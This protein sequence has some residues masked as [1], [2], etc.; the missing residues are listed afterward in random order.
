MANAVNILISK[1]K[2]DRQMVDLSS[3]NITRSE[4]EGSTR[5]EA[6]YVTLGTNLGTVS[7]V[8]KGTVHR[9]IDTILR[10]EVQIENT[11]VGKADTLSDYYQKIGDMFGTKGNQTSFA[12]KFGSFVNSMSKV[13][14]LE[15]TV[16]KRDV[17]QSATFFATKLSTMVDELTRIQTQIDA[18]LN[19]GVGFI[20]SSLEDII[21][22]NSTIFNLTSRGI[23]STSLEDQ[24]DLYVLKIGEYL[25]TNNVTRSDNT[26]TISTSAGGLL[27]MGQ[28]IFELQYTPGSV[29]SVILDSSGNDIT[30]QLTDGKLGGLLELRNTIIPNFIAELDEMSRVLRDKVNIIHNEGAALGGASQLTGLSV[31]PGVVGAPTGTTPIQGDGTLRVALT[32]PQGMVLDYKDVD[33]TAIGL[34]DV[35]TLL[36]TINA[37]NFTK[38][39]ALIA[40]GGG[41]LTFNQL[42]SGAVQLDST[43][44]FSLAIGSVTGTTAQLCPGAFSSATALGFSHFFGLNNFFNTGNNVFSASAQSGIAQSLQV[45]PALTQNAT[46]M[47]IGR[48]NGDVPPLNDI[49]VGQLDNEIGIRLSDALKQ[50]TYTFLD[51]GIQGTPTTTL[52]DYSQRI[53]S[54]M[55]K[56]INESKE[57]LEFHK[58]TFDQITLRANEISGVDPSTELMKIYEL[59]TSQQL[60]SKALSIVQ[61]MN[62]ELVQT[63][64][65]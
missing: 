11:K 16:S 21:E 22:L 29:P 51:A 13:G 65:L 45:N 43:G 48:L 20:N 17:I 7:S 5:K 52:V 64:S 44:G 50:N 46:Y 8:K 27:C 4:V 33:L 60:A 41:T 26:M 31:L 36:A 63:L 14:N 37:T 49:G 15:G 54:Y 34:T 47:S 30:G 2:A 57:V 55:Q 61:S 59:S 62:R 10:R 40:N 38:S 56:N 53:M 3:T 24:R 35:S 12:H 9:V 42:A 58:A 6:A 19:Q 18:E 25:A 28:S 1:V 39:G 23:D 32:N